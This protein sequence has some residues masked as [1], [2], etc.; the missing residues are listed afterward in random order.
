MAKETW[1]GIRLSQAN[2]G[3]PLPIIQKP[4]AQTTLKEFEEMAAKAKKV[5]KEVDSGV[6]RRV[7]RVLSE[8]ASKEE[9]AERS[10]ESR[11]VE[12]FSRE[13]STEEVSSESFD[14]PEPKAT[15]P[16]LATMKPEELEKLTEDE[17]L[18]LIQKTKSR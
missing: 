8:A 12:F 7:S 5:S 10:D 2:P 6:I 15:V 13:L 17:F 14:D 16:D 4:K 1:H 9:D 3:E 18:A 11:L